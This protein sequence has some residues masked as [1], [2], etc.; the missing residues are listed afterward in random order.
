MNE[1]QKITTVVMSI[2]GLAL[3]VNQVINNFNFVL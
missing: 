2:I 3:I 1:A